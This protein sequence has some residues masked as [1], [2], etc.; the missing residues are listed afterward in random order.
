MK[1]NFEWKMKTGGE[2]INQKII[3]DRCTYWKQCKIEYGNLK[4]GGKWKSNTSVWNGS[5]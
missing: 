3:K 5:E 2:G 1:Y 4:V